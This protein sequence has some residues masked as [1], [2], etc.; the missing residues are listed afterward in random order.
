[1]MMKKYS[2]NQ[3]VVTTKSGKLL[4]QDFVTADPELV[5]FFEQIP[6]ELRQDKLVSTLRTGVISLN[7]SHVGERVDYVEKKFQKLHQKYDKSLSQ[8]LE[9]MESICNGYMGENGEFKHSITENFGE[10]SILSSVLK[11]E[12]FKN[13]RKNIKI[14][15]T[16]FPNICKPSL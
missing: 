3:D 4:I 10:G 5:E 14:V 6:P 1:M 2:K 12:L 8:T 7:S 15:I 13:H 11:S 9:E 16:T